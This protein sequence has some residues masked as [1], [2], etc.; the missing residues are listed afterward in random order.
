M[1][2]KYDKYGNLKGVIVNGKKQGEY[3][4]YYDDGL[5]YDK[6]HIFEVCNYIDGKKNGCQKTYYF[7]GQIE[8]I[9][10]YTDDKQNGEFRS[11]F[12]NGNLKALFMCV[13]DRITGEYTHY[14]ENGDIR[15]V[16]NYN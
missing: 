13:N 1:M 12:Q 7:N 6:P 3:I 4:Q 8:T 2:N 11:Y 5:Y 16:V 15:M 10:Y 9:C 14:C